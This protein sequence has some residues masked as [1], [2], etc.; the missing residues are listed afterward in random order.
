MNNAGT[1]LACSCRLDSGACVVTGPPLHALPST[2]PDL[3]SAAAT[4]DCATESPTT[5][6]ARAVSV[7]LSPRLQ[8][9]PLERVNQAKPIQQ[10]QPSCLHSH[11]KRLFGISEVNTVKLQYCHY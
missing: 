2:R 1:E 4:L 7:N 5:N 3:S 8:H 6:R 11:S 10:T 9:N